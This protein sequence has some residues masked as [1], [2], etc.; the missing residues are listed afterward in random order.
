MIKEDIKELRRISQAKQEHF[1]IVDF[2]FYKKWGLILRMLVKSNP[3]Y[4]PC[5][6]FRKKYKKRKNIVVIGL[7]WNGRNVR[8]RSLGFAKEF[9]DRHKNP[10]CIYC[11]VKLTHENATS[12][13]IIPISNGGNN[14]QINM[15]VVCN[16]C[17]NERGNMSFD[18]FMKIKNPELNKQKYVFI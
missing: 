18:N 13:H 1:L 7:K 11:G 9:I 17:N 3:E 12:D 8:R 2:K 16:D 15:V 10:K 5:V 4:V 14:T 6:I